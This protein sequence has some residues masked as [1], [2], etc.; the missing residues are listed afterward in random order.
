MKV[1]CPRILIGWEMVLRYLNGWVDSLDAIPWLCHDVSHSYEICY[2][3]PPYNNHIGP[4]LFVVQSVNE[5][6]GVD[7]MQQVTYQIQEWMMCWEKQPKRH[8]PTW[9]KKYSI[10]WFWWFWWWW[11]ISGKLELYT[12]RVMR[13]RALHKKHYNYQKNQWTIKTEHL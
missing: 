3:R 4:L 8:V 1:Q 2:N 11:Q 10:S 13:E 12:V 5:L 9:K 6:Q 7:G